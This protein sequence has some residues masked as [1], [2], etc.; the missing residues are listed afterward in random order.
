M[1]DFPYLSD[2]NRP[3]SPASDFLEVKLKI[4][5]KNEN[6]FMVLLYSGRLEPDD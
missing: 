4:I 6:H 1:E 2:D 3:T 5:T